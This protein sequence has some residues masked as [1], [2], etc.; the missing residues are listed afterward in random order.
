[1]YKEKYLKYKNKYIALKNSL[2]GGAEGGKMIFPTKKMIK[3]VQNM[4]YYSLFKKHCDQNRF[5][6]LW[7][8]IGAGNKDRDLIRFK[9]NYDIALTAENENIDLTQKE[10]V[11]FN[12]NDNFIP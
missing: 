12:V 3:E 10:L 1:M 11:A 6:N 2:I 7:M 4:D 9:D 5:D 8:I